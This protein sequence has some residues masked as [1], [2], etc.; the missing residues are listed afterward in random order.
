MQKKKPA[1]NPV[2]ADQKALEEILNVE[3]SNC[4][5]PNSEAQL[6]PVTAF[7]CLEN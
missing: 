6:N 4:S 3:E 7:T 2:V 1:K 5:T